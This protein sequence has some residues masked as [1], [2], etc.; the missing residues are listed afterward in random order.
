MIDPWLKKFAEILRM[1]VSSGKVAKQMFAPWSDV[2][3][4]DCLA[5]VI[6]VREHSLVLDRRPFAGGR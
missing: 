4:V 1:R 2:C 6:G 3:V 5:E